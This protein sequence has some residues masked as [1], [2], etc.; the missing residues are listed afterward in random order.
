LVSNFLLYLGNT[1]TILLVAR[2]FHWDYHQY[3]FQKWLDKLHNFAPVEQIVRSPTT[4]FVNKKNRSKK[5][6]PIKILT[7][8]LLSILKW[9]TRSQRY[10]KTGAIFRKIKK[11]RKKL[12]L[13]SS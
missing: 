10:I 2:K 6:I 4:F 12:L 7:A 3:L 11:R 1:L 5:E 8:P 9:F 13:P